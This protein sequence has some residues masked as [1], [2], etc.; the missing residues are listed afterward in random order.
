MAEL[1]TTANEG[2]VKA[3]LESVEDP[4]QREESFA[5]LELMK[6]ASGSPPVM[7]GTTI[8]GFGNSTVTYA[9]GTT[10]E[11]FSVGFSPRKGKFSLYI[12]NDAEAQ[13]ESLDRLG[14][15]KHGKSCVWVKRLSDIDLGVLKEIV[16]AES[17]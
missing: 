10:Q 12:V 2:N 17:K 14:K 16:K 3:F 4:V 8:V 6:D 15:Y 1:K 11:W 7:Y 5:L 9:N 13:K